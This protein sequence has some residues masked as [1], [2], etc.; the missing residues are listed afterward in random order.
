LLNLPETSQYKNCAEFNGTFSYAGVFP[1]GKNVGCRLKNQAETSLVL[2][3]NKTER[4]S[5][6]IENTAARHD[7]FDK[8]PTLRNSQGT[9]QNVI[10]AGTAVHRQKRNAGLSFPIILY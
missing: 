4:S 1:V 10:A 7:R 6:M 9:F 5:A 3:P 8:R 2:Y